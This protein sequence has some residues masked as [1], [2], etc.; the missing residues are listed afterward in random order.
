MG[1]SGENSLLLSAVPGN[2]EKPDSAGFSLGLDYGN[3]PGEKQGLV[4]STA[5]VDNEQTLCLR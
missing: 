5:L 1:S 4:L 2:P 3:T